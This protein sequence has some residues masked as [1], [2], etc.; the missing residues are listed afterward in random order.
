MPR[1]YLDLRCRLTASTVLLV[2]YRENCNF[3]YTCTLSC[4]SVSAGVGRIRLVTG[5][6]QRN[7]SRLSPQP[8]R[9]RGRRRLLVQA[10]EW[11][12]VPRVTTNQVARGG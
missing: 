11:L 8:C 2:P 6:Q 5:A 12:D 3:A 7:P 4:S 10:L 1:T 9:P